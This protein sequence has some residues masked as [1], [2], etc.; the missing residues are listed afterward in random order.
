M[1]AAETAPAPECEGVVCKS[2][3]IIEPTVNVLPFGP[4]KVKA[5]RSGTT[6]HMKLSEALAGE[7]TAD[8]HFQPMAVGDRMRVAKGQLGAVETSMTCLVFDLD[9]EGHAEPPES[10]RRD[11][12]IKCT[13]ALANKRGH[14]Y[15]T[16][17]GMR[18]LWRIEPFP[19]VTLDDAARWKAFYLSECDALSERFGIEADRTCCDWTR[20]YRLPHATRDDGSHTPSGK[21]SEAERSRQGRTLWRQ[22]FEMPEHRGA[23]FDRL[24]EKGAVLR[25][26]PSK[27]TYVIVCPREDTHTQ[28]APGDGSTLLYMP[29]DWTES[30]FIG[31]RHNCAQAGLTMRQW[32]KAIARMPKVTP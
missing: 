4:R 32:R 19:I 29:R 23:L 6:K 13:A 11:T 2:N 14:I 8:A 26:G 18:L 12:T 20:C 30:G 7:W 1:T 24:H 22:P 21:R 5:G 27:G 10:W 16:K 31:C 25:P 28:G 3:G 17:H 15:P 9:F